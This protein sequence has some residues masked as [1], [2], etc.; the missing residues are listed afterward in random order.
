MAQRHMLG[1]SHRH[2]MVP[3][4]RWDKCEPKQKRKTLNPNPGA[5]SRSR[6]VRKSRI[7]DLILRSRTLQL[8]HVCIRWN[9]GSYQYDCIFVMTPG[10]SPFIQVPHN[11]VNSCNPSINPNQVYTSFQALLDDGWRVDTDSAATRSLLTTTI[12]LGQGMLAG[13]H[14][15]CLMI[16][17]IDLDIGTGC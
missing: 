4:W 15:S 12:A 13:T 8:L 16:K 6:R 17:L 3:G 9:P 11:Q 14:V 5:F 2:P 1:V 10:I 7:Y